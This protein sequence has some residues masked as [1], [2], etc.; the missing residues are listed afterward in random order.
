MDSAEPAVSI[1][2]PSYNSGAHIGQ[3]I[4][5]ILSQ[6]YTNWTLWVSDD[7]STDDTIK[8]VEEYGARDSRIRLIR[9]QKNQGAGGARNAAIAR[10]DGR[11]IAFLDSDDLWKPEK[12]R[13]Q[14]AFMMAKEIDF[15]FTNYEV[16]SETGDVVR[17]VSTNYPLNYRELLK[18]N[19]IG[20]LTAV[21]DAGKLGKIYMPEVRKRNDFGLWLQILKHTEY[22][23]PF[24]ES[25]GYYR[26]R[27]NSL[28]GN[29]ISAALH[30]WRLLRDVE[31]LPILQAAYYFGHYAVSSTL[32]RLSR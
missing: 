10:C 23:Y 8:I 21:Y 19:R 26:L 30:T 25:L 13:R 5:S 14:I 1:V 7:G 27:A 29:K 17:R 31:K 22:A 28:S 6:T 24:P 9:G 3:S 18:H 4:D 2:M 11:F 32:I 16:V 15:S 12:L 20:C